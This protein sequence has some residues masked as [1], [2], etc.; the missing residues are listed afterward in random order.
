MAQGRK[1]E[2]PDD[3]GTWITNGTD[4]GKPVRYKIRPIPYE[5]DRQLHRRV[6]KDRKVRQLGR[7]SAS[8]SLDRAREFTLLRAAYA[9]VD[10]DNFALEMVDAGAAALYSKFLGTEVKVGAEPLLDG[11]WADEAMK[12]DALAV[13]RNHAAWI[14][15]RAD[16]LTEAEVV[17]EEEEAEDF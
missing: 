7:E 13:V 9:L 5:V 1:L 15:D 8:T 3:Q 2:S 16:K 11:H 12:A 4:H 17:Q 10:T 6:Y 14:S